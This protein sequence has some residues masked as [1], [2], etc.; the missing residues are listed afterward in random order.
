MYN[1]R[2]VLLYVYSVF[3]SF[4]PDKD[5]DESI[6]WST[7]NNVLHPVCMLCVLQARMVSG[8]VSPAPAESSPPSENGG[9][10]DLD[11]G[12]P[13]LR[14]SSPQVSVLC[15]YMCYACTCVYVFNT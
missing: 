7:V 8:L 2:S 3:S 14:R 10:S 13:K 6:L 1:V 11:F 4:T 12:N 5:K 9:T 15:V